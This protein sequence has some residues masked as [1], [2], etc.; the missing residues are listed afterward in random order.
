MTLP[1]VNQ[2][3]IP[4]E[5]YNTRPPTDAEKMHR[6]ASGCH[7]ALCFQDVKL[8]LIEVID[9][10]NKA[11]CYLLNGNNRNPIESCVADS[12]NDAASMYSIALSQMPK[13]TPP[14]L[15]N[16]QSSYGNSTNMSATNS[17]IL[18]YGKLLPSGQIL[19]HG[20]GI[21]NN[22]QCGSSIITDRPFSTSFCPMKALTNGEHKGKYYD[23]NE[24]N[25]IVI[26]VNN[27]VTKS[28]IFDIQEFDKGHEKEVL[29]AA[30]AK[31]TVISKTLISNCYRVSKIDPRDR[32]SCIT[33]NVS[34]HLIHATIS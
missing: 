7:P 19:F 34:A 26:T 5:L 3:L 14:E 28:F 21:L 22:I 25:I 6:I 13:Q 16:Y 33:K 8:N 27:A 30:G 2:F 18:D 29:F 11:V 24:A 12:L 9:S 32:I 17:K 4:Y 20:G 15:V 10:P 23:E 1:L 31:L